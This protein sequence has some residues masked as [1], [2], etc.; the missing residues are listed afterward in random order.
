MALFLMTLFLCL[1]YLTK[2]DMLQYPVGDIRNCPT[3][4]LQNPN[5]SL[6]RMDVLPGL[7]F[8]NLRNLDVGRVYKITYPSCQISDDGLYILPD[9]VYLVPLLNSQV[10]FSA[11]VYDHF[12]NWKSSTSASINVESEYANAFSK[13]SGKFSTD[14][15]TTKTKMVNSNSQTVRVGL[16]HRLYSVH[17]NPDAQLYPSFKTRVL[18]IAANIQNNTTELAHY[19]TDFLVRDYG[20]H[21]VT[22]AEAGASLYQTTFIDKTYSRQTESSQLNIS[23]TASASFYSSFSINTNFKFSENHLDEQGYSKS[24]T[25]SH[26]T[27]HGGPPFKLSNF[28][29]GDWENG[30]LDHLVAID[31]RGQPLYTALSTVNLPE[32]PPLLLSQTIQ[33]IYEAITKYY[34]INTHYG[35][36]DPDSL[37]FNFQS[38][39]DDG[40]CGMT[41]ENYIF[42]GIFQKCQNA[43][44]GFD[45]CEPALQTNPL[46]GDYTCPTGYRQIL[47]DYIQEL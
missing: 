34:K 8:D 6:L 21:V 24:T 35:C 44:P 38:N 43:Q 2:G 23:A 15:Q 37:N 25:H 45:V 7:G 22:S 18:D 30:I 42:G 32:L 10:D 12:D 17:I 28:S 14:Y 16:R 29:Y 19:L 47:L 20:T 5:A 9:N 1:V 31:R 33:Y 36:T 41:R 11:E 46:T 4:Q 13:I 3:N 40:S 39:V 26:T 27:T